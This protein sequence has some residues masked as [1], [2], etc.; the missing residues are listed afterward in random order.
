MNEQYYFYKREKRIQQ[1][2][3]K[4][5]SMSYDVK[6]MLSDI[7]NTFLIPWNQSDW[8][9]GEASR[10][11]L[12]MSMLCQHHLHICDCCPHAVG[13]WHQMQSPTQSASIFNLL[14]KG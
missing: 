7:V 5:P 4:I 1:I 3:Y 2:E 6:Q 10:L 8:P 9:K 13:V 12:G 14:K 11:A